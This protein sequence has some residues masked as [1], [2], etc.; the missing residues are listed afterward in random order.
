MELSKRGK[1]KITIDIG[2]NEGYKHYCKQTKDSSEVFQ[3]SRKKYGKVLKEVHEEIIRKLLYEAAT[4]RMPC[5][6]PSLR[7]KKF[8]RKVRFKEDGSIDPKSLAINWK[9]TRELWEKNNEA[10]EKKKLVYF[11]NDHS[12]GYSAYIAMEKI[13]ANVPNVTLYN[14][15]SARANDRELAKILLNPYSKA[16]YYC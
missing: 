8:K 13:S 6:L 9:A 12:D 15:V 5:G 7:V 3:V 14:F 16:D 4:F 1:G 2:S 10:K 11:I